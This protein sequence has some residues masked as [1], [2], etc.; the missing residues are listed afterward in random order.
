MNLR[1]EIRIKSKK[2]KKNA[3]GVR[4]N[5]KRKDQRRL[6]RTVFEILVALAEDGR[7][8]G[9]QVTWTGIQAVFEVRAWPGKFWDPLE[10]SLCNRRNRTR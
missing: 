1:P 7:T 3:L 8:P 9:A 4:L 2:I 6:H 10:T 5:R